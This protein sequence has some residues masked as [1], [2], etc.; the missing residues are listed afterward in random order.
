MKDALHRRG[1]AR[2]HVVPGAEGL[3]VRGFCVLSS[4][5]LVAHLEEQG[6]RAVVK[7]AESPAY[8]SDVEVGDLRVQM[9]DGFA[10]VVRW[11]QEKERF[12][13]GTTRF[14]DQALIRDLEAS[15]GGSVRVGA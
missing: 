5:Q 12:S 11:N 7:P 15:L 8:E 9:G 6:I 1:T 13:F 4:G 10:T 2:G 14:D 3:G